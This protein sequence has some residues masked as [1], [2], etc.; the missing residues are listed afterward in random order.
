MR[1][2]THIHDTIAQ[3]P[4]GF[5]VKVLYLLGDLQSDTACIREDAIHRG[6][7]LA[8]QLKEIGNGHG[9]SPLITDSC[10]PACARVSDVIYAHMDAAR[11]KDSN[12]KSTQLGD[13]ATEYQCMLER[14]RVAWNRG[15]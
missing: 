5:R 11:S 8:A 7:S 1:D 14:N 15:V 3:I 4:D 6:Y 13:A 10:R 9:A 2:A 12:G